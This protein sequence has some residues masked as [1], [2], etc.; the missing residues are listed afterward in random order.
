MTKEV[1]N[2]AAVIPVEKGVGLG[3][4]GK[5]NAEQLGSGFSGELWAAENSAGFFNQDILARGTELLKRTRKGSEQR[6]K[7]G[8]LH[9]NQNVDF[10]FLMISLESC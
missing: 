9:S 6:K 10:F 5:A 8:G 2:L 1:W 4:C 7:N 3:V